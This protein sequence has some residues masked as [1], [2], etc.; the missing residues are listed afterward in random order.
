[1]ANFETKARVSLNSG[2]ESKLF[3]IMSATISAEE[4]AFSKKNENRLLVLGFIFP[5]LIFS[6]ESVVI[7]KF[8]KW[9]VAS[10]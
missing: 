1:M 3:G 6:Q 9:R 10:R 7:G 5:L 4:I 8:S 2:A